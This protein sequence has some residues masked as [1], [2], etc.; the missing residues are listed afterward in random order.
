MAA[1]RKILCAVDF[2]DHALAA[3]KQAAELARAIG[4]ELYLLHVYQAA[5]YA[6]TPGIGG[7]TAELSAHYRVHL[8]EMLEQVC[9]ECRLPGVRI[10]TRLAEGVV[11]EQIVKHGTEV[12][13]DMIALGTR[14]HTSFARILLGSVAERVVRLSDRPVLTVPL[15]RKTPDAGIFDGA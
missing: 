7:S 4:A 15:P 5:Q 9:R 13:A 12:G 1:I 14:G 11:Y 8:Q 6:G 2:S 3:A 10:H